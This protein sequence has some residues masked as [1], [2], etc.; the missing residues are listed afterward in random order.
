MSLGMSELK[1]LDLYEMLNLKIKLDY[2]KPT[3]TT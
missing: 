3:Y 2:P 1:K